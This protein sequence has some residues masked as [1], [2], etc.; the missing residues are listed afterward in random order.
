MNTGTEP[1]DP[2]LRRHA[3]SVASRLRRHPY[4][5]GALALLIAAVAAGALATTARWRSTVGA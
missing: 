3:A 4:A 2:D 1:P 5:L